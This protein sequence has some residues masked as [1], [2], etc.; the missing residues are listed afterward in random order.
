MR[1]ANGFLGGTEWEFRHRTALIFIMCA[2]VVAA[3]PALADPFTNGRLWIE[4]PWMCA[5][6]FAVA[7]AGVA[8]R[9]WATG[10][11]PFVVIA[12]REL[13]ATKLVDAGP[14]AVTRNPLYLGTW[15]AVSSVGLILNLWGAL[16][17]P[18]VMALKVLRVIGFEEERLP[19]ALGAEYDAYAARVPRLVPRS[20]S[21]VRDALREKSDWLY[22]IKGNLF[23]LALPV[24]YLAAMIR[25]SLGTIVACVA[26]G[27]LAQWPVLRAERNGKVPRAGCR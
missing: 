8:I 21:A 13:H 20:L 24:G 3:A 16:I 22:G 9:I 1:E 17:L 18:A 23:I 11:L 12:D 4:Q 26:V 25:P 2:A 7:A 15:L 5:A 10:Y 19:A 6:A 14:Y 27:C